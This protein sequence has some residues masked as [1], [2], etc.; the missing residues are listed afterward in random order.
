MQ[1][2]SKFMSTIAIKRIIAA[3]IIIA[4]AL[5]IFTMVSDSSIVG[6]W[7]FSSPNVIIEHPTMYEFNKD[8]TGTIN[9][10]QD[11]PKTG[12]IDSAL[13][14]FRK[15]ADPIESKSFTYTMKNGKLI[16]DV[17]GARNTYNT[18]KFLNNI[19]LDSQSSLIYVGVFTPLVK[20]ILLVLLGFVLLWCVEDDFNMFLR[21][22]SRVRKGMNKN[23][24]RGIAAVLAVIFIAVYL[25]TLPGIRIPGK[26]EVGNNAEH[27]TFNSD[28]T[29]THITNDIE[30]NL[31]SEEAF[32]YEL[33]Q[34]PGLFVPIFPHKSTEELADAS[35][36]TKLWT[37]AKSIAKDSG[38]LVK[39]AVPELGSDLGNIC[40]EL[41][42][43]LIS[44]IPENWGATVYASEN[45]L[46][47]FKS[48]NFDAEANKKLAASSKISKPEILG[49]Y[50]SEFTSDLGR[51]LYDFIDVLPATVFFELMHGNIKIDYANESVADAS[52]ETSFIFNNLNLTYEDPSELD[53][54]GNP[55]IRTDVA[56]NKSVLSPL[57]RLIVAFVALALAYYFLTDD[58][59]ANKRR[60]DERKAIKKAR[61]SEKARTK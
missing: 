54:K 8:G 47:K 37:I 2:K 3:V 27:Y 26:W 1:S 39:V 41:I 5:L 22:Q 49:A 44:M 20:I 12:I 21:Y 33:S 15:D 61:K 38:S 14:V 7:S 35:N 11:A 10:F 36:A 13:A 16:M 9:Y 34:K 19:T 46:A 40:I 42:P 57:L 50:F 24:K 48:N 25:T 32:T 43:G 29:G 28:G 4:A 18:T 60:R 31:V 6:N 51:Y 17:D 30:G 45:A 53:A 52:Y 56:K 58:R 23:L 55:V 59:V